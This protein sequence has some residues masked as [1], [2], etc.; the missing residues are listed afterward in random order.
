MCRNHRFVFVWAYT[1]PCA[2][3]DDDG[4]DGAAADAIKTEVEKLQGLKASLAK[5]T[6]AVEATSTFDGK[7]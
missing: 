5:A 3:P 1:Y 2:W 4:Q 7:G 6:A